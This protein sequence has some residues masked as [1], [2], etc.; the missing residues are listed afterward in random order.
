MNKNFN[1]IEKDFDEVEK[2]VTAYITTKD[3]DRDGDVVLPQGMNNKSFRKNPVVLFGHNKIGTTM[4][5]YFPVAKSLWE[6][7][8]EN[9]I[10]AKIKFDTRSDA[11]EVYRLMKEGFLNAFSVGFKPIEFVTNKSGGNDYTKWELLEFSIVPIPSNAG[12]LA[13]EVK[14]FI[15]NLETNNKNERTKKMNEEYMAIIEE[16]KKSIIALEG[17]LKK[18]E[19]AGAEASEEEAN[20]KSIEQFL[21]NYK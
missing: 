9:G 21:K 17:R 7:V 2:S 10:R 1:I 4:S 14:D 19:E 8:D 12:A 3:I 5:D 6:Q 16:I 20:K 18:L 15:N 11:Q 13:I